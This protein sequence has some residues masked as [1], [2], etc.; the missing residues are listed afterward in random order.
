MLFN[1]TEDSLTII[2]R[3]CSENKFEHALVAG[4]KA[5]KEKI[6]TDV[7]KVEILKLIGDCSYRLRD[8][9][10]VLR[11]YTP[12]RAEDPTTFENQ[13]R[14]GEALIHLKKLSAAMDHYNEL[15]KTRASHHRVQFGFGV[16]AYFQQNF[17]K[18][19]RCLSEAVKAN[20]ELTE[21]YYY[22]GLAQEQLMQYAEAITHL[23]NSCQPK[24]A[25][26]YPG[27]YH[28]GL[29]LMK[30]GDYIAAIDHLQTA[31]DTH[32]DET[33]R[34]ILEVRYL[35]G[36]TY[37]T[38]STLTKALAQYKFI[39]RAAPGF[40]DVRRRIEDCSKGGHDRITEYETA[41]RGT[42]LRLARVI[43]GKVLEY[44][45]ESVSDVSSNETVVIGRKNGNKDVIV[46]LRSK[47][48]LV[49]KVVK[50]Y[51]EQ[52]LRDGIKT[53]VFFYAG[54]LSQNAI[55]YIKANPITIFDR[56]KIT[57]LLEQYDIEVEA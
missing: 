49:E 5:L 39:N 25:F 2:R 19:K 7:Q 48:I 45:I 52:F 28:I 40:K 22:L 13:L 33:H 21:A 38:N 1:K 6:E 17:E 36:Q 56:K 24:T 57:K 30:Q 54:E 51:Q 32:A 9:K 18:A 14:F 8:W 15:A 29:C 11:V 46:F 26:Y 50:D 41:S 16:I 12:L 35:L 31:V 42:F 27:V 10:E 53:L 37:Q 55:K 20:R 3:L 44:A 47:E 43:S 4:R 23:R 34:G